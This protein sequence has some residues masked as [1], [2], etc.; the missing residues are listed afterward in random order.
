MGGD[1][2]IKILDCTL[3]DG[4]YVNDWKFSRAAFDELII[5]L[6]ELGIDVIEV[7]MLVKNTAAEF[8]TKFSAFENI[9]PIPR[10]EGSKALFTVMFT[11]GEAKGIEIPPRQP[12]GIEAIRLAY[13]KSDYREALELAEDLKRKGYK[14]FLQAMATFMYSDAELREMLSKVNRLKPLYFCMVD[15]F[16]VMYNEDVRRMFHSVDE[17]LDADIGLG[18]H[19]HNNQQL[20]LSNAIVFMEVAQNSARNICVDASIYGM[21]RGAGNVPLELLLHYMNQKRGANYDVDRVIELW[22]RYL[23]DDYKKY[24][25]GYT[26]EYFFSAENETNSAYIWYMKFR[27]INDVEAIKSILEAI[28]PEHRYTLRRNIVDPLIAEHK[29]SDHDA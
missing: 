27:G 25:W 4:G 3:R 6:Q 17:V 29:K 14:V 19:A 18:F 24:F 15:S 20:A 11:C 1:A 23:F 8:T 12:D 13:F 16:G 9:P 26:W 5:S 10:V 7:G 28:P 22:R 2:L 21:G